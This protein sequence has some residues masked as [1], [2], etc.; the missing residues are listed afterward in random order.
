MADPVK[1]KSPAGRRRE[2][3]ARATRQRIVAAATAL[4]GE[5]GYAATTVGAIAG[6]AGV[7]PATVYQ[8][9]GTK[10]AILKRALDEAIVGDAE[11]LPL[12]E[13]DWVAAARREPDARRR[14]AIVVGHTARTAARTA[15]LKSVMRDAAATEPEI[16]DLLATDD[17]R[18]LA[19]QRVLV[20]IVLGRPAP[21][22][23]TAI[24]YMLVSSQAYLLAAERLGWTEDAWRT[25]LVEVLNRHLL[26]ADET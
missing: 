6:E 5:R 2:Q 8:A 19:T 3:R 20:G 7:A 16:R 1:G 15:A 18:R 25:W 22:G 14:L 17:A 4:F 13:R 23:A 21:E 10:S 11:P 26:D 24:F 12:L 9:F